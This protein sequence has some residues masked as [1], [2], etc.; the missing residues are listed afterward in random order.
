MLDIPLKNIKVVDFGCY[1]AGPLTG[2]LLAD[3]GAEV[4]AVEPIDGPIFKHSA[5]KILGRNKS[6]LRV[7]LKDAYELQSVKQLI[8][9]AD[10][11]RVAD[12]IPRSIQALYGQPCGQIVSRSQ[13]AQQQQAILAVSYS[14]H[15][16]AP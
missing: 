4:I 2:M 7:N 8:R 11:L 16:P 12:H 5:N 10:I 15:F 3:Q 9:S 14:L 1:Y 13:R 6:H